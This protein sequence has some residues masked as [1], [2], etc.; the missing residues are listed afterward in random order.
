MVQIPTQETIKTND[1][2]NRRRLSSRP[3]A[4]LQA[5]HKIKC[6]HAL[7]YLAIMFI[8]IN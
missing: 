1:S 6:I 7:T 2:E 5:C 3:V 4:T 8:A